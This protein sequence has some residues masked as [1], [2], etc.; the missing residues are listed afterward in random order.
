M[1]ALI[2]NIIFIRTGSKWDEE[3]RG[4]FCKIFPREF[5]EAVNIFVFYLLGGK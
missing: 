5:W 2:F 3:K 1:V 4:M